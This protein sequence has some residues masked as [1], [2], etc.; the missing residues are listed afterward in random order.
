MFLHK[1]KKMAHISLEERKHL[2]ILIKPD[3]TDN[4]KFWQIF[5]PFRSEK[6]KSREKITLAKKKELVSSE[7][8]VAKCFNQFFSNPVNILDLPK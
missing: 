7:S 4:K 8:D 2:P 5:N 6:F 1:P 3:I